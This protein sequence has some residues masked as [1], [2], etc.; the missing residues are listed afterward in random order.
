MFRTESVQIA[1]SSEHM[2][3]GMRMAMTA[4]QCNI[5][6]FSDLDATLQHAS[7]AFISDPT[8]VA[9]I[10]DLGTGKSFLIGTLLGDMGV[11]KAVR[12]STFEPRTT[13]DV[14]REIGARV[15]PELCSNIT[16]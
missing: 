7:S 4:A 8:R 11:V 10:G 9:L 5:L 3:Q 13:T 2:V 16:T 12:L 6:F 15:S 1:R 14:A